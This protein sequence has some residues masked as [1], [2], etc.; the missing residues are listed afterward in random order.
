MKFQIEAKA[1][2]GI[3]ATAG[4]AIKRNSVP[5]LQCVKID[6]KDARVTAIGTDNIIT[7]YATATAS[8]SAAGTACINFADLD[9]VVKRMRGVV[10]AEMTDAGLLLKSDRA[11]LTIPALVGEFPP[12]SKPED[13]A[14][15]EGGALAIAECLPF[16]ST[17]QAKPHIA[18]VN[19]SHGHA[20]GTTGTIFY[21]TPCEG[22]QDQ[23][24]PVE[25]CTIINKIGGRLFL[26]DRTWRVEADGRGA[27]GLLIDHPY[28]DWQ[29]IAFDAETAVSFDADE[30]LAAINMATVGRAFEVV[31]R[32]KD[33]TA[34]FSGDKFSGMRIDGESRIP[35]DGLDLCFVSNAKFLER[36]LTPFSGAV[37]N[38]S[39]NAP[40]IKL[41][42]EARAGWAFLS[43]LS[44]NRTELAEAA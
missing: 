19:F 3:V 23:T 28:V 25:G 32:S 10:S 42:A 22:G 14:E 40:I 2:A 29:R 16:A 44:D 11:S 39:V 17:E 24:V 7:A 1:L 9:A 35:C 27:T 34:A 30:A 38:V 12:M 43:T 4:S 31:F 18:G 15:I 26:S 36:A 41:T 37:V 5:I 21:A 13:E 6:A 8:V 20:V 33:G